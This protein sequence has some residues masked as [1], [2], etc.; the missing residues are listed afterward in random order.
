MKKKILLIVT[1][2]AVFACLL[3]LSVFAEN[4]IIKLSTL[5]TLAEIHANPE[6]YVSHLDAFD[7]DSLGEIDSTSVVVLSDLAETPTYYV[8]PSYYYMRTTNNTVWGY[9]TKLNEAITAADPTA[10]AGYVGIGGSWSAGGCK[11]L[12][13]YEVPTYVTSFSATSKFE[14]DTNLKEVYFP[15]HIVI[16]EETGLE[17]EVAYVTSISGQNLFSSCSSLEYV[18]N[19]EFLPAALVEGNQD[20]FAGCKSLKEIK[21]PETAKSIGLRCFNECSSLTEVTLPNSLTTLSKM[22]FANCTSLVTFRFGSGFNK[23]SSPNNDYETFLNSNKLKYVYLPASFAA[24][25]TATNNQF[26]NIFNNSQKATFF[27]V[28][29]YDDALESRDKFKA[30]NANKAYGNAE[31][32]EFDPDVDY[33]TYAD[34]LGYSIIVYN[35]SACE[36]FYN[37]EHNV[38]EHY[39]LEYSG[40]EF[41]STAIKSKACASCTYKVDKSELGALFVSL[42]YSTNGRGSVIQGFSINSDMLSAYEEVLG[43]ITYGVIAAGDTREDKTVGADVFS[44]EK[45]VFHELSGSAYD[46]FQVMVNGIDESKYDAYIFFCAYVQAG[47]KCYYINE[48]VAD[49]VATSTTYN[50][51]TA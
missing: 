13:R 44:F 48:G 2:V 26:K 14:A 25:V 34:T 4:K 1:L 41:L 50:I 32:V 28:G 19:S 7:G 39:S 30:T 33:T 46:Y 10:F 29:S 23:F 5:P 22:A 17:K 37:G 38:S 20:G 9:L 8:F 42:G 24:N 35:Y 40:E 3:A 36:A 12:I 45:K 49:T 21:I 31:I 16:D 51:A 11:Y 43:E 47:E 18:H 27:L 15:T 6:A